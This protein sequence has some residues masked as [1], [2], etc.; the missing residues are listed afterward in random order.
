MVEVE[1]LGALLSEIVVPVTLTDVLAA[2]P[3]PES[4]RSRQNANAPRSTT[5]IATP[6]AVFHHPG[7]S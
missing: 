7:L 3:G 6:A 1:R 5:P 2:S 4:E